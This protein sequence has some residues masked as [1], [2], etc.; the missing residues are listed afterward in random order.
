MTANQF[1]DDDLPFVKDFLISLESST[2][3]QFS[4]PENDAVGR[5][6]ISVNRFTSWERD[7]DPDKYCKCVQSLELVYV[8]AVAESNHTHLVKQLYSQFIVVLYDHGIVTDKINIDSDLRKLTSFG[9]EFIKEFIDSDASAIQSI[10][11]DITI[12]LE[13]ASPVQWAILDGIPDN[14]SKILEDW[15][16]ACDKLPDLLRTIAYIGFQLT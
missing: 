6:I 14:S 2:H 11:D 16:T 3:L 9:Q 5:E 8:F 10:L 12:R 15:V 13:D 1:N 7:Q 4:L